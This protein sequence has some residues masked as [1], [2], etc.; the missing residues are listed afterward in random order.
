LLSVTTA[1]A[2]ELPAASAPGEVWKIASPES[3]GLSSAKLEAVRA[4]LA[5]RNTQAFLVI[6]ND[7]IVCEW[8]SPDFSAGQKHG[9]AS[10][11][12]ALV[13]G[14]S[15]AVAMSEGRIALDDPASKF[16]P[17]WRED[18]RNYSMVLAP[19]PLPGKPWAGF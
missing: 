17:Q 6:R 18:P 4:G 10:L 15:F 1:T 2:A 19:R 7:A 3:Q 8:Y 16:I 9:S 11:A 14:L 5:A 13:G 12:K